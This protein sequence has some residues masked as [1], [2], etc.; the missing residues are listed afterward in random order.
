MIKQINSTSRY[1]DVYSPSN[2]YINSNTTNNMMVG[3]VR[4]NTSLQWLEVYD[5][6]SWV[7]VNSA[8]ATISLTNE[9]ESILDWAKKKKADEEQL[10]EMAKD[11]PA[12]QDLLAQKKKIE[13]QIE[14]VQ[15][16]TKTETTV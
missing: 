2:R 11:N 16:L 14:V 12:I 4:F 6:S 7:A 1:V 8:N 9:A 3:S 5:G 15:I 10:I 13:E